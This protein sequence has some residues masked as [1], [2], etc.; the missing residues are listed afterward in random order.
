[1]L[2]A[3]DYG[4]QPFVPPGQGLAMSSLFG[5]SSEEFAK[6]IL[7]VPPLLFLAIVMAAASTLVVSSAGFLVV[8]M[9]RELQRGK[10]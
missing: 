8:K 6:A 1:M 10:S 9:I 2:L 4:M 5:L 7:T 3:F